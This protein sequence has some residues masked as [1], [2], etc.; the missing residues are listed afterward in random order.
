MRRDKLLL[1]VDCRSRVTAVGNGKIGQARTS[2]SSTAERFSKRA[3]DVTEPHSEPMA[4]RYAGFDTLDLANIAYLDPNYLPEAKELAKREFERR[5]ALLNGTAL[6]EKARQEMARR[7]CLN[8]QATY[9]S[10]ERAESLKL[11]V[12]RGSLIGCLWT[13]AL[14]APLATPWKFGST[15]WVPLA[16]AGIWLLAVVDAV[17]KYETTGRRRLVFVAYIPAVLFAVSWLIRMI[18]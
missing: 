5:G 11:A 1:R 3:R 12:Y 4:E 15:G 17:R 2:E 14:I 16:I 18:V 6:L 8:E 13:F 7:A 10:L 9:A